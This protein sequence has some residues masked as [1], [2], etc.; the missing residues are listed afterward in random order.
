MEYKDSYYPANRSNIWT[1][2]DNEDL[3]NSNLSKNKLLEYY[4]KNPIEYSYNNYGF[5]TPD[6]FNDIENGKILTKHIFD[7]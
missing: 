4:K 2:F 6:D 5:R 7:V 3:F 1:D